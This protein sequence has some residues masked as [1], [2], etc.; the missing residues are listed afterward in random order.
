MRF[1]VS[2]NLGANGINSEE[3]I[4]KVGNTAVCKSG[5]PTLDVK[6]INT[7]TRGRVKELV[8]APGD[9]ECHAISAANKLAGKGS[10]R[11]S[12]RWMQP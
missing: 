4:K 6:K 8:T 7:L 2:K 9:G 5:L 12:A 1:I 11:G 3:F 10:S